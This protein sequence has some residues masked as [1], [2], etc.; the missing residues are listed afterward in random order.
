MRF[1][2]VEKSIT[3]AQVIYS[4]SWV[5]AFSS[6]INVSL[7]GRKGRILFSGIVQNWWCLVVKVTSEL[8]LLFVMCSTKQHFSSPSQICQQQQA[9]Q[10]GDDGNGKRKFH[11]MRR[12]IEK[13]GKQNNSFHKAVNADEEVLLKI[14]FQRS[15]GT[16]PY[17]SSFLPKKIFQEE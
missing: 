15:Q 2:S 16:K 10:D 14:E 3:F 4:D 8:S 17:S 11:F 7:W 13:E 5:S 1:S 6:S 12:R 9:R